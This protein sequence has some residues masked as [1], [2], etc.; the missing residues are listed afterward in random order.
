MQGRVLATNLARP[1]EERPPGGSHRPDHGFRDRG[2]D[3][4]VRINGFQWR[5]G[6]W[7]HLRMLIQSE[8]ASG[9]AM[10]L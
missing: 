2:G 8:H 5:L 9:P 7:S 3:S 1:R 10:D 6:I 4:V